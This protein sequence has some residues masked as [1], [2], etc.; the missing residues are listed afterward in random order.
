MN[1]RFINPAAERATL[2]AWL[3]LL[4]ADRRRAI[5]ARFRCRSLNGLP[6]HYIGPAFRL[7]KAEV[8]AIK[9]RDAAAKATEHAS[10]QVEERIEAEVSRRAADTLRR[11]AESDAFDR[12]ANGL[13][14]ESLRD[15]VAEA[16]AAYQAAREKLRREFEVRRGLEKQL[17][18]PR[19]HGEGALLK[20]AYGIS[21]DREDRAAAAQDA[22]Y[23]EYERATHALRL[24]GG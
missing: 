17:R 2:A 4:P 23:A 20:G 15:S 10:A 5:L 18:E 22:A 7:A 19:E 21:L 16:F 8:E 3:A 12:S 9:R 1:L 13:R 14:L 6:T 11:R 24:A